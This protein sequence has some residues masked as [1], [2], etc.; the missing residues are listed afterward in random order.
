MILTISP[1]E[2]DLQQTS[3]ILYAKHPIHSVEAGRLFYPFYTRLRCES[4]EF[5]R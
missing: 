2:G 4:P 3:L 5:S 1:E